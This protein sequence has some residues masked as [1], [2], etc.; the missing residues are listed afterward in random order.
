MTTTT[1]K[2]AKVAA[3]TFVEKKARPIGGT[4]YAVVIGGNGWKYEVLKRY[5]KDDAADYAR[6]FVN[7]H[8]FATEAGDTY[9]SDIVSIAATLTEVDGREPTDDEQAEWT[10]L[11]KALSVKPG[12]VSIFG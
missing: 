8:G 5:A 11:K 4:A 7:V 6:W 1:K 3:L 10:E 12:G 2:G 9:V